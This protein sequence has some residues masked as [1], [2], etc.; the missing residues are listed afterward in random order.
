MR[1]VGGS[2]RY[3]DGPLG[4]WEDKLRTVDLGNNR[5]G[6]AGAHSLY[7]ALL[8]GL[9][10]A[11]EPSGE[12]HPSVKTVRGCRGRRLRN[13]IIENRP[14]DP[15]DRVGQIDVVCLSRKWIEVVIGHTAR[16]DHRV[17][18]GV[19]DLE[20]RDQPPTIDIDV[21]GGFCLAIILS[22]HDGRNSGMNRYS[23]GYPRGDV[24]G[25]HS[26]DSKTCN[27]HE[28]CRHCHC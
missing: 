26:I 10:T 2:T 23:G 16:I 4:P 13:W 5:E 6:A 21:V 14:L 7:V 8:A 18:V 27:A 25:I 1:R 17:I 28:S 12:A 3:V 24:R 19:V 20:T 9:G 22:D 15:A 11:R